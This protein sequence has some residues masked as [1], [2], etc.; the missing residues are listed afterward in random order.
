MTA[1]PQ[2]LAAFR[3]IRAFHRA[4]RSADA[5]G[6]YDERWLVGIGEHLTLA[7]FE[8]MDGAVLRTS[9]RHPAPSDRYAVNP[10]IGGKLGKTLSSMEIPKPHRMV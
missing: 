9:N 1:D 7:D 10:R 5:W 2:S 6:G 3:S 4:A 8:D